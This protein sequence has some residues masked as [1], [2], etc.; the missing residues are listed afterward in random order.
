MRPDPISVIYVFRVYDSRK[1]L[2]PSRQVD[3]WIQNES[4]YEAHHVNGT[5]RPGSSSSH[6]AKVCI[7]T[8]AVR[9]PVN[10]KT[11]QRT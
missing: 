10:L 8:R 9:T 7:F 2:T 4:G 1:L 6:C 3:P 5:S 11:A